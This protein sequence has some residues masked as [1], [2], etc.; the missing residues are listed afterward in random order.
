MSFAETYLLA[1]KVRTKLTK[2][3]TNPKISLRNLV[4]QANMLDN[5][6][7]HISKENEKRLNN[8]NKVKFELPKAAQRSSPLSTSVVEYE[9]DSDSDSDYL[10][11]DD[12][13]YSSEEEDDEEGYKQSQIEVLE[14]VTE[15][16]LQSF[17]LNTIDEEDENLPELTKSSDEES[18]EEYIINTTINHSLFNN[19]LHHQRN[20][21]AYTI[22]GVEGY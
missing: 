13:Y 10:D 17:H 1:S 2:D 7:D 18:E 15:Q 11:D 22:H 20:D 6:M 16:K 9:V 12:Y 21:S 8:L 19:K 3:A 14:P 5:L 4:T